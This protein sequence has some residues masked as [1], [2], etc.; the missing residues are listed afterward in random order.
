MATVTYLGKEVGR[1]QVCPVS[2][3]VSAIEA[4][5]PPTTRRELRRFLGMAGYYRGFCRNFSTV[6]APLTDLLSPSV[7][8]AWSDVC[9]SAFATVKTLLCSSPVLSAP[10][11]SRPFKLEVDAS[12]LG[13]G[14]VL[15]QEDADGIDHPVCY[16]SRKFS[17]AQS[18]YSTIEQ[19][20]LALLLALQQFEVYVGSSFQPI[21]VF[22]DH[23]PL[24]FLQ[25]MYVHVYVQ[26]WFSVY[27][28]VG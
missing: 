17:K 4:F 14:A 12:A 8:F 24:V 25:H 28:Y 21:E 11:F 6:V 5:P 16:F 26:L 27:G 3:K 9:K 15:I 23:N 13:A 22:T 1:G 18:R 20:T 10:D 7:L 19:E 2:A